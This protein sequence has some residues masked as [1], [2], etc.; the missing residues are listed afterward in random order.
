MTNHI[1]RRHVVLHRGT[2][3]QPSIMSDVA[4][5]W[6]HSRF[7]LADVAGVVTLPC[8]SLLLLLLVVSMLTQRQS[9][10]S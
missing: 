5:G 6:R 2:G 1:V 4:M 3:K 10:E 9:L 8:R 7:A